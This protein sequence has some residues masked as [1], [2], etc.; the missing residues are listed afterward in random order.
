MIEVY[1]FRHGESKAIDS[2]VEALMESDIGTPS[3]EKSADAILKAIDY[4][5]E[6]TCTNPKHD[7]YG[8]TTTLGAKP[9][10]K[11]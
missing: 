9:K 5:M 4:Q 8:K 11:K 2:V 10:S 6:I 7:H 1:G 3:S